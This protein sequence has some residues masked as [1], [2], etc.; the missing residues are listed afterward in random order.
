[1]A[2][3]ALPSVA[4]QSPS[5]STVV[6]QEDKGENN[7]LVLKRRI[8]YLNLYNQY[9]SYMPSLRH[10]LHLLTGKKEVSDF[11]ILEFMVTNTLLL[12][13]SPLESFHEKADAPAECTSHGFH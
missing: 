8:V 5:K 6:G 1:M 7:S 9:L 13:V 2:T 10:A 4:Q 12:Y 11:E 3:P